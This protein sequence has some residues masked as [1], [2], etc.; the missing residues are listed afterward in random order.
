MLYRV[1]AFFLFFVL[2]SICFSQTNII[3][4]N[5]AAEQVMKGNYNPNS[6]PASVIINH[7]DSISKYLH[8]NISADSLKNYILKLQTFHNRN[9]GSDTVSA[10]QGIGAARR[11]AYQKFQQFSAANNN[12]LLPFYLQ[13]NL[14]ICNMSQ[15]K[16][17]C[18]VL[19][20]TDTSDKSIVLI[21]GHID[22]RCEVL[23]DT[24]CVAEGIED[25]ASG[26]ALVIELARVISALS[27]HRTVVFMLTIGEEQ[28]LDGAEAMADFV[29]QKGIQVKAV[30][31]NDVIGGIIC[32]KTS[33]TPSC[34]GENDIDSMHVRFFSYG[35][36]NS[37]HKQFARFVK[38]QYKEQ[39]API[40]QVPMNIVIMTPE[41][42]TN[43][44][45]DHI[46]FRQHNYTAMRFTS[47]NEH[48]DAGIDSSYTDRQ[49]S[50][51]D[52]LGADTDNDQ[53]VDSFFIDF[54]YLA[55]NTVINGI[56][57]AMAAIGPPVPTLQVDTVS[58][59]RLR[60]EIQNEFFFTQYRIAIRSVTNDW[61]SVY[62][63]RY[64]YV[65]T[66]TLCDTGT[67]FISAATMN[68]KNVEGLFTGE[69]M[70]RL[71]DS[72]MCVY[73]GLNDE[74][75][76]GK[77]IELLQNKP[78]PFDEKTAI[79]VFV[80]GNNDYQNAYLS[81]TDLNGKEIKR[82]TM[83]L[84]KGMNETLYEHGYHATGIYFYTL[85]VDGRVVQTRR[86]VF[87]N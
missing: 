66:L 78:N 34:P 24:G 61:D 1:Y 9:S 46:P 35:G 40:A 84:H 86:M 33:S 17:I 70:V 45:G 19:P 38:L 28:G 20:G 36:F 41:D 31:N 6:F 65:D 74:E 83:A 60:I 81:I 12:R 13:F 58:R 53:V 16:N 87:A 64:K 25:N 85:F 57:A 23:C 76:S 7:P 50:I 73:T 80:H 26:T 18:A 67:F 68:F 44:G 22:S 30:L 21:E 4:T 10:T 72:S 55:R 49:H 8:Q 51:R 39:I 77:G 3:C 48:G 5:P 56:G 29:Q 62:F 63:M 54:N 75:I 52:V 71:S 69:T 42:R 37:K 27:L 59:N 11:W 15:H 47:A 2:S 32:G 43:R 79:S 14:S 82:L